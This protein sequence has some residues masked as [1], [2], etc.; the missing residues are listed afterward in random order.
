MDTARPTVLRTAQSEVHPRLEAIVR[1]HVERPWRGGRHEPTCSAFRKVSAAVEQQA[2][3]PLIF[4]SGCGTGESTQLI[5]A[6]FP[7]CLVIGIDRSAVRLARLPS[8]SLS[9][10][11]QNA[12]WVRAE[13]A[14][15][16]RLA[17]QAGWRLERHCLFYPNPWPKAAQLRRRW[18]GHPVFPEMLALGGRLEMRTNWDVYA[19]E[20]ARAVEIVSGRSAR[21]EPVADTGLTSP[22]ERK[23][24][25]RADPLY[26]V[27][28]ALGSDR[29]V[30]RSTAWV[31]HSRN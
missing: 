5:A 6:A 9:Y 28:V 22:F 14:A 7:Q 3:R 16:W 26:R 17:V 13:L 11:E 12:L 19:C 24:R 18:H 29:T 1:R 20:F 30:T 25:S 8:G 21:I 10:R 31:D 15:F 23:F 27:R 2:D 4:D